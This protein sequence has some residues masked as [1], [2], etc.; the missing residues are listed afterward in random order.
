[1]PKMRDDNSD[2]ALKALF[3][4]LNFIKSW[5]LQWQNFCGDRREARKR[6]REW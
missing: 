2:L 6:S 3:S 5:L 1:M 4:R